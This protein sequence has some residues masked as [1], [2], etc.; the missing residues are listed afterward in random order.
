[1]IK[2]IIRLC[3]LSISLLRPTSIFEAVSATAEQ[4]LVWREG[5]SER[6]FLEATIFMLLLCVRRQLVTTSLSLNRAFSTDYLKPWFATA[7]ARATQEARKEHLYLLA[8]KKSSQRGQIEAE[9]VRGCLCVLP[10]IPVRH[11]D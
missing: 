11:I 4:W 10:T 2:V 9:A 1:V 7:A 8:T 3:S 6:L 5:G